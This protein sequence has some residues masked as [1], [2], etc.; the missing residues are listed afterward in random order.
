MPLKILTRK[1]TLI[2]S[3]LIDKQ[4][5]RKTYSFSA[6]FCVTSSPLFVC[7]V[8]VLFVFRI[9]FHKHSKLFLWKYSRSL[10]L[11][12]LDII[13]KKYNNT[14]CFF[15][16]FVWIHWL[17]TLLNMFQ[18]Q[19]SLYETISKILQPFILVA[20]CLLEI[21]LPNFLWLSRNQVKIK[22][23][24]HHNIFISP[25][26]FRWRNQFKGLSEWVLEAGEKLNQLYGNVTLKLSVEEMKSRIYYRPLLQL[27]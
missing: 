7:H 24:D 17:K 15:Y 23:T 1:Q 13:I 6:T 19:N 10:W 25:V 16:L 20:K 14:L 8:H 22:S 4:N 21:P 9:C 3:R 2:V 5:F 12:T 11:A 26:I 27:K 18:L